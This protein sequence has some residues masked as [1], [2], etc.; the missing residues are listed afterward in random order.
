MTTAYTT[1]PEI[2]HRF[3]VDTVSD[4]LFMAE[5]YLRWYKDHPANTIVS[6]RWLAEVL[7]SDSKLRQINNHVCQK[8]LLDQSARFLLAAEVCG[9]NGRQRVVRMVALARALQDYFFA[10]IQMVFY[11]PPLTLGD[12]ILIPHRWT[13]SEEAFVDACR[14]EIEQRGVNCVVINDAEQQSK[15]SSALKDFSECRIISLD[16]LDTTNVPTRMDQVSGKSAYALA[17]EVFLKCS[18]FPEQ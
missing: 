12:N 17:H 16:T 2:Q 15:I 10:G 6:L 8:G 11:G 13:P 9:T 1:Y 5:V 3:S 7:T 14:T 18:R 4:Y